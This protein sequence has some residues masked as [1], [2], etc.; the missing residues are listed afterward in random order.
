[1]SFRR[2]PICLAPVV[3]VLLAY[4]ALPSAAAEAKKTIPFTVPV[5][6]M[7]L[8]PELRNQ[9]SGLALTVEDA[10]WPALCMLGHT[11]GTLG[12]LA[13]LQPGAGLKIV[14]F[15]FGAVRQEGVG[16]LV[17]QQVNDV[18]NAMTFRN[19]KGESVKVTVTRLSP[20]ILL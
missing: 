5:S 12:E 4:P 14:P 10:G 11:F 7:R 3:A 20:A 6:G 9:V 17:D 18:S 19:G 8:E 13:Q 2:T 16:R 15:Q 1:M